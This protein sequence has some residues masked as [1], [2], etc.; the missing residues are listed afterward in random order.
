MNRNAFMRNLWRWSCGLPE[1]D[2]AEVLSLAELARTEWCQ[3]FEALMRRRL[4]TG[5]FRY[6]RLLAQFKPRLDRTSD[7][8]RRVEEYR[9]THNT[10][11]LVD[12]A[13]IAMMEFVEG[14]NP[15]RHFTPSDD[16]EHTAEE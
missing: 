5:G 12:I 10:E 4:I 11:H 6:G 9:R 8:A 15:A 14:R 3:P 7:M 2:G 16:G 13:N 1:E